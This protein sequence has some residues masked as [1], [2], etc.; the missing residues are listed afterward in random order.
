ML[1]AQSSDDLLYNLHEIRPRDAVRSFRKSIIEDYPSKGCCYCGM[2]ARSWTLDHIIPRSK[3]GPTRRWN[4]SKCCTRCNGNKSNL[5][6][7]PWYRPQMF[8]TED[9]ENTVFSWMRDNASM[10]AMLVLEEALREGVL[11]TDALADVCEATSP[12][13]PA[14]NFWDEYCGLYPSDPECLIYDV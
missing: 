3:G 5:D 13:K 6:L 12:S 7:L 1:K 14:E 8:W 11:D 9:R 2:H 10:D 4:L